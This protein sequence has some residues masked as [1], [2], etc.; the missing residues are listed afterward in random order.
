MSHP[1]IVATY[2]TGDDHGV[3]Y[4]VMELV[5]GPTLRELIDETHGLAV[6]DVVR[7]GIEIAEALEAAHRAGIVRDVKPPTS[8][9]RRTARRR[10]P[11][12]ASPRPG[13]AATSPAPGP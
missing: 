6:H 10:S 2:D 8:W 12:S 7:I 9:F 11:T 4:I 3:A 13:A 1:N 5:R